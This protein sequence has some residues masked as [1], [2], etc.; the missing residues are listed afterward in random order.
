MKSKRNSIKYIAFYDTLGNHLENRK[1][2]LSATNKIDYIIS[3]IKQNGMDVEIVSPSWTK[4]LK[5]FYKGKKTTISDTVSLKL[6][7]TFGTKYKILKMILY[8]YTLL[9]LMFYL[10]VNTKQRETVIVYHAPMLSFPLR[11]VKKIKQLNIILEVEEIYTNV[12]AN[13]FF[14]KQE[15]KIF[16]IADKFIFPTESL[17]EILNKENKPH[18]IIHGTYQVEEVREDKSYDGKIHIV[19]AGTFDKIK[20]GAYNAVSIARYLPDNYYMHIIGF[21]S[22]QE[23]KQLIDEINTIS[24]ISK[25]KITFD[26][27]LS[28]ENYIKF[29][30]NCD[31]GLSTQSPDAIYNETSFPSKILSYMANGLRVVTTRIK[32]I[33]QSAIGDDVYYYNT[34]SPYDIAATILNIDLDSDYDSRAILNKLNTNTINNIGWLLDIKKKI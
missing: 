23:K 33:E 14:E 8:I 9:Q 4:N 30:Q 5:G 13:K 6:F 26:G 24:K 31:I 20:G 7:H 2:H 28:G 15:Y 16:N 25:C 32:V 10:I 3:T 21:G 12:T 11:L 22:D 19:Y 27:L 1:F 18:I 29:I 34:Q 17:N